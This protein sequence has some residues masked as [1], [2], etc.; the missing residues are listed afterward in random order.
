[1]AKIR[2]RTWVRLD[3]GKVFG[4]KAPSPLPSPPRG[5]GD[6]TR[7]AKAKPEGIVRVSGFRIEDQGVTREF[8]IKNRELGTPVTEHVAATGPPDTVALR[9]N[10]GRNRGE[11]NQI[12]A[13]R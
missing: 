13:F 12:K 7:C 5:R 3:Q 8:P 2:I 11:S 10:E 4:G 9:E 6:K 1:M